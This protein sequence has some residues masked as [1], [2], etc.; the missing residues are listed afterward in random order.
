MRQINPKIPIIAF[1]S[2][3]EEEV[4]SKALNSGMNDYLLKPQAMQEIWGII[5]KFQQSA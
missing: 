1:T 5:D 3:P 4:L 2:L